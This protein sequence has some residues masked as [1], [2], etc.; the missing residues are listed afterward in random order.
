MMDLQLDSE[1]K[2]IKGSTFEAAVASRVL[3][4]CHAVSMPIR[5]G[6]KLKKRG[7]QNAFAE[8]DAYIQV[9]TL[10]FLVDCKA[11]SL[12]RE[13][14]RGDFRAVMNRRILTNE[15]LDGSDR[16]TREIAKHPAGANYTIPKEI[17]HLIP[18]VCSAFPEFWWSFDENEFLVTRK[19]PR[20]C[21]YH[22]LVEVL[23]SEAVGDL[24]EKAFAIP[25]A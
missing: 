17:T 13:Y 11:Y 12:T 18:V 4:D 16:R 19:I 20:V 7:E 10:L 6:L 1:M 2:R 25:I 21:T 24:T 23:N 22:E 8:L 3:S 15:W 14:F 9:G 5:P